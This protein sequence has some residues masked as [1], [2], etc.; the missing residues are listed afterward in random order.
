MLFTSDLIAQGSGSVNGL[1]F[2]HNRYGSYIR[3]RSTPVN[4]QSSRQQAARN[5]FS[6]SAVHWS[7]TL[8]EAQRVA[9]NDYAAAVPVL[10]SIGQTVFLT[11]S[12]MFL[13]SASMAILAGESIV[14]DGPTVLTLPEVDGTMSATISEATQL[15]SVS[16]DDTMAWLDEDGATMYVSQMK[17]VGAGRYYLV[18]HQRYADG[19]DGDS[20]TPP[21][22]PTT[23]ACPFVCTE[24]QKVIVSCRI[25]RA[26]GRLSNPFQDSAVVAA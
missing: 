22:S 18:G 15:I 13:R 24:G 12:A 19:I 26:D 3:N 10:N 4:P 17:P 20:V 6:Q 21:T 8:T 2:S 25:G 9:W 7:S 5:A 23:I 14:A 1:T 16:F 11:G